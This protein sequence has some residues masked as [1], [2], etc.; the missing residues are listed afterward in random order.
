VYPEYRLGNI[1][2]KTLTEMMYSPKQERFGRDK[3]ATLPRQCKECEVLSDCHGECPKNRIARTKDGED[4][5]N[6]LC[7]GYYKF[8]RHVRPSMDFMKRELE[9]GRPPANIMQYLR[10]KS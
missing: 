9:A 8:Y 4:G 3:Y 2:Q 10:T 5:L 7:E 6:C 1:R